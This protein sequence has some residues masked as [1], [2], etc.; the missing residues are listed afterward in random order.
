MKTT[1]FENKLKDAIEKG[2]FE[3]INLPKK[4]RDRYRE[5]AKV[6]LSAEIRT[7]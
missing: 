6:V 2:D 4:E 5:A 7:G 1:K 3:I